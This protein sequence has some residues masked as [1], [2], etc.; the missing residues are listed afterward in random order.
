LFIFY[1]I[2]L[3]VKYDRLILRIISLD[4]ETLNVQRRE[5]FMY[6]STFLLHSSRGFDD[7]ISKINFSKILRTFKS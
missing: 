1:L 6:Y 7:F 5:E 3:F 2:N 4:L